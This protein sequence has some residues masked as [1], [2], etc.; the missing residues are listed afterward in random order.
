MARIVSLKSKDKIKFRAIGRVSSFL[1]QLEKVR[2]PLK[3]IIK[4]TLAVFFYGK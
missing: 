3:F 4:E 1:D 2:E